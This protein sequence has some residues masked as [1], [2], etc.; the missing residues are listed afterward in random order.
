MDN[1]QEKTVIRLVKALELAYESPKRMF[2]RGLLWGL[3]R[4]IGNLVGWLLLV[5]IL[6]YLFK[7]SG[8]DTVFRDI[9]SAFQNVSDSVNKLP[10]R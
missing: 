8:L 2:W 3:G 7:I 6:F 4:G 1:E 5:A 10:F 9:I